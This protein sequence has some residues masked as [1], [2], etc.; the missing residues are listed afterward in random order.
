MFMPICNYN[1]TKVI[2][3]TLLPLSSK[4]G[5]ETRLLE[6]TGGTAAKVPL[7]LRMTKPVAIRPYTGGCM[8][9]SSKL[10]LNRLVDYLPGASAC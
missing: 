7:L 9:S 6:R 10:F 3:T 1:L 5:R 8:R 2:D 4:S